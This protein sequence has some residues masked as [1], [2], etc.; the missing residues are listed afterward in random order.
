MLD[1]EANKSEQGEVFPLID[2]SMH[3]R[4]FELCITGCWDST[5]SSCV[6]VEAHRRQ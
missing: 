6:E 1:W 3:T 4:P 5:F 2:T